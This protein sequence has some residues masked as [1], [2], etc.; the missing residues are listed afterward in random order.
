MPKRKK[1]TGPE[2]VAAMKSLTQS[3]AAWLVGV[4]P[5][6]L[7]D[8][9]DIRRSGDGTY[10]ATDLLEWVAGR[11]P[12]PALT[13]EELERVLVAS[14]HFEVV[15]TLAVGP[16]IDTLTAL[17]DKYG[18]PGLIVFV[19]EVMAYFSARIAD[20]PDQYRE[21]TAAEMRVKAERH[22]DQEKRSVAFSRLRI[23]IV[24]EKCGK[25]R[26]GRRWVNQKPPKDHAV[27]K[28]VC[29]KCE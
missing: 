7:R 17:K 1:A 26:R 23:T 25:L 22:V 11:I 14:E 6:A 5:R 24:C 21:P 27:V 2:Q 29:P 12:E 4:S 3:A 19:R 9:P 16:I 18:D 20:F 15:D 28:G 13:D 10:D 8:H